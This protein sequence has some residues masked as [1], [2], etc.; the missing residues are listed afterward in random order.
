M[1]FKVEFIAA[2]SRAELVWIR[3]FY[4]THGTSPGVRPRCSEFRSSPDKGARPSM[5]SWTLSSR[6]RFEPGR[7]F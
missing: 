6:P 3:E 5:A 7:S 4:I 1:V 2:R